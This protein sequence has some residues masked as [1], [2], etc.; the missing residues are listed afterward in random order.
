MLRMI[1]TKKV[2]PERERTLTEPQRI[3]QQQSLLQ[4]RPVTQMF[5]I[6]TFKFQTNAKEAHL[7]VT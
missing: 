4:I 2:S 1:L 5:Q 7:I 6:L 3:Q